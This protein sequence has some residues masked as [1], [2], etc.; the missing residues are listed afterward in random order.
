M[1]AILWASWRRLE[2]MSDIRWR[3]IKVVRHSI[4]NYFHFHRPP[5][6]RIDLAG[7]TSND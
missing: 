4:N 7:K 5:W 1:H 3:G 2:T 6:P